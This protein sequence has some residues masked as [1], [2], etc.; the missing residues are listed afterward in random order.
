LIQCL[1]PKIEF[2]ELGIPLLPPEYLAAAMY[3]ALLT[4]LYS[5]PYA[6]VPNH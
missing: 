4:I 3:L 5:Y 1:I 6:C 2:Q